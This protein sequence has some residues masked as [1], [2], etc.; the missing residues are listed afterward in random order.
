LFLTNALWK[1]RNARCFRDAST[2][3]ND[4]MALIKAEADRWIK[5]GALAL[6]KAEA[7]RWI[8]AGA[9]GL[10]SLAFREYLRPTG[11]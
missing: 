5:E 8:K 10:S 9:Q 6:I 11:V 1:E 2:T 7:D 3:V 4:M